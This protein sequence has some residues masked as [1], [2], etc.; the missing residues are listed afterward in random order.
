MRTGS[1]F[2]EM[3][4]NFIEQFE[5]AQLYA[6]ECAGIFSP[7][8][9]SNFESPLQS[10]PIAAVH[11]ILGL[12]EKLLVRIPMKLLGKDEYNRF[13]EAFIVP[14]AGRRQQYHGGSYTGDKS[15]S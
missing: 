12:R 9:F 5:G 15:K 10:F 13:E 6:K 2:E 3:Y 1:H 8:N 7:R 11:G 4:A 14:L